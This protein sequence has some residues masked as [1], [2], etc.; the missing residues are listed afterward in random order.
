MMERCYI[1]FIMLNF[2][3]SFK[4]VLFS[5]K[6]C[7]MF[8]E[9]HQTSAIHHTLKCKMNISYLKRCLQCFSLQNSLH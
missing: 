9:F 5:K 7:L 8:S 4:L 6:F 1:L 2:C 3:Y